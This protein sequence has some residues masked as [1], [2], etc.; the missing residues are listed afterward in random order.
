MTD[1]QQLTLC[2][3]QQWAL[4]TRHCQLLEAQGRAL[5]ACDRARFCA[6]QDDYALL[7]IDLE[8]QEGDRADLMRDADG[9]ACTLSAL[10]EEFPER[11]RLRLTALR[12]GL[13][14]TLE[15]A[16]DLSRRNQGLIQNELKYCAFMLDLFVEAGRSAELEFGGGG[17][18]RRLLLDRR[19]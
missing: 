1:V 17:L 7:L 11:A 18:G 9:N 19:A 14:G 5:L 15:Q 2:L 12:D 4:Q 13:R 6:L 8:K 16:Q 3:R 10:M